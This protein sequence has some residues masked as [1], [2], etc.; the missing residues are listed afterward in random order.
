MLVNARHVKILPGRKTDVGDAAWLAELLEHGLLRGSFVPPARIRELRDLTRYR[1]QL[2]QA[3][4]AETQRIQKILEDAGIKLGLGRHRR[5]GGL[6]PGDDAA[7]WFDGE[8]DPEV[9]AELAGDGCGPSSRSCGRRC[10][11]GSVTITGCWCGLAPRTRGAARGVPSASS[12]PHRPGASPLSL[13]ARDQLDT[14]PGWASG[15]P[16]A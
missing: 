12:T 15:P 3:H 14:S 4:T 5:A 11:G 6:R 10:G 7:P 8:R 9:L 16:S 13:Q 1:K 2:I